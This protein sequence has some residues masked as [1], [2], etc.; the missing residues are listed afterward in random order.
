MCPIRWG[1][2][3]GQIVNRKME[4]STAFMKAQNDIHCTKELWNHYLRCAFEF[5]RI[6][7]VSGA[8]LGAKDLRKCSTLYTEDSAGGLLILITTLSLFWKTLALRNDPS[9]QILVCFKIAHDVLGVCCP[10]TELLMKLKYSLSNALA[11]VKSQ[12]LNFSADRSSC[13]DDTSQNPTD[14]LQHR[15]AE[16]EINIMEK[17]DFNLTSNTPELSCLHLRSQGSCAAQRWCASWI[18]VQL[19]SSSAHLSPGS[20]TILSESLC[21]AT[22]ESYRSPELFSA[23]CAKT[24][25]DVL[26]ELFILYDF[27]T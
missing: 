20:C 12:T 22:F 21:R 4:C 13:S 17:L 3:W 25:I 8:K 16:L 2:G 15:L 1:A 10:G 26:N 9:E 18:C 19:T 14:T 11:S 6:F 23:L 5:S 7:L 24:F 27:Y